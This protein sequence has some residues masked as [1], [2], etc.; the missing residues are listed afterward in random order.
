MARSIAEQSNR[1][2]I[3]WLKKQG[4]FPQ[5]GCMRWGTVTWSSGGES[6]SSIGIQV[7]AGMTDEPD[8]IKLNYTHTDSWTGEK[9]EMDYKVRLTTTPCQFGG[10]RYWFVCP[11]TK[12]GRYCGRRVGVLYG[13]GKWFGC[14]YCAEVAYQAQFEGGR[15]R[16][17]SVTEPDVEK[18]YAEAR[19]KYY[20]GK[21]T[22]RYR[23][24]LRLRE[25]MDNS[26]I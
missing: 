9:S 8:Y 24:Y 2:N 18:A 3:F 14:R 12:N 16:V 10:I 19:T 13:V 5:G 4:Y 6:K 25:K 20:K 26:W 22:R 23:R 11:L 21:P 17:G 15:F 1:L 7:V